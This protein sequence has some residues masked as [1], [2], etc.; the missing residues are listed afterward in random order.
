[1]PATQAVDCLGKEA[2][3]TILHIFRGFALDS[4]PDACRG[5]LTICEEDGGFR[6]YFDFAHLI[7]GFVRR[8]A[9]FPG[10]RFYRPGSR[11]PVEVQLPEGERDLGNVRYVVLGPDCDDWLQWLT[12]EPVIRWSSA[13]LMAFDV[14]S[15]LPVP[16]PGVTLRTATTAVPLNPRAV[17]K[18]APAT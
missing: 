6:V 17:L 16:P 4:D 2:M 14:Y 3:V 9:F 10:L 11:A 13:E 15:R 12:M 1:M 7:D 5:T 18:R 8:Q